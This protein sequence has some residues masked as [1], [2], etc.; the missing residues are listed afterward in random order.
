MKVTIFGARG[1]LGE[2]FKRIY[3]DASCPS[4][5]IADSLAVAAVLDTDKPDVVINAAGKTG[6]PNVDWCEDHKEETLHANVTGPLV[7]LNE[8]R[9]RGIYWV[10]LSSGCIYSGDNG[11]KGFSEEDEPNFSGSFYSRTKFWSEQMLK[12]FPDVLILRIRMPFDDSTNDRSLL[13]K[14][15]KFTKVNELQNSVTYLPDFLE[16][17]KILIN[18][19]RSGIY[20][21]VNPGSMSPYDIIELYKEIIDPSHHVERLSEAQLPSVS[22]AGRS[23]CILSTAKLEQEGIHVQSTAAAVRHAWTA[24]KGHLEEA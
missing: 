11:G 24:L 2:H 20:N 5:D 10:H 8:C 22:K 21:V 7:L 18:K 14:I 1:Y 19:R 23:N 3:P 12:E 4:V 16:V 17:A 13:M 6:R 9:A 15:R